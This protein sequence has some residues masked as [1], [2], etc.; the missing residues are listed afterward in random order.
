M[1]SDGE[2]IGPIHWTKLMGAH[3]KTILVKYHDT[4]W[5]KWIPF[6]PVIII[7]DPCRWRGDL[8]PPNQV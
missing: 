7:F 2:N 3:R 6:E 4:N 1:D 5:L 8:R